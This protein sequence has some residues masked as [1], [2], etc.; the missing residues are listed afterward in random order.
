MVVYIL[1]HF[2]I[3]CPAAVGLAQSTCFHEM[4]CVPCLTG[5]HSWDQGWV[6]VFITLLIWWVELVCKLRMLHA[7]HLVI[8]K[9]GVVVDVA[10]IAVVVMAMGSFS[11]SLVDHALDKHK[12]RHWIYSK[13]RYK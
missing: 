8:Y 12:L 5:V 11:E 6:F 3:A 13:T 7:C 10:S 2:P 9:G 4:W 1:E